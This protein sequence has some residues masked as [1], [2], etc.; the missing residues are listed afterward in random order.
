MK[1]SWYYD[2]VQQLKL[3]LIGLDGRDFRV[4]TS[5]IRLGPSSIR[6][7][8]Q[9]SGINRGSTY[10]SLKKLLNLGMVSYQQHTE[11]TKRYVAESPQKLKHLITEKELELTQLQTRIEPYL[12]ELENIEAETPSLPSRIYE[13]DE[14]VAAILRDVLATTEKLR[15]KEYRAISSAQMRNY[16]YKHFPNFTKQRLAKEIFVKV[17]ATGEGGEI[18]DLSERKWLELPNDLL[19]QP[20][21]Y[22]IIYGTKLAVISITQLNIPHGIVID[23]PAIARTHAFLFDKLWSQAK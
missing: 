16:M 1:W 12:K 21:S 10:E 18:A 19:K 15:K 23:D 8:A 5:L 7:I 14:G 22:L 11:K 13:E 6:A 20:M 4:Y 3:E 9:I 2:T 17:L